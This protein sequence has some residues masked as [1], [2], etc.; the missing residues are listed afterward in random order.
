MAHEIG[1][2]LGMEHDFAKRHGGSGMPFSNGFP[3]G[4]CENFET[5]ES[6]G[7]SMSRW[8]ACS[9]KDFIAHYI[10]YKPTWCLA[11]KY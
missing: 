8:S 7:S 1:H 9:N 5:I 6:Y 3:N 4:E 10:R 2:N 11:S